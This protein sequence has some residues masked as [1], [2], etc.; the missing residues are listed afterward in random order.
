M[1]VMAGAQA[2]V[3]PVRRRGNGDTVRSSLGRQPAGLPGDPLLTNQR[4][5]LRSAGKG[6]IQK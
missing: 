5:Q 1:E 6:R 2:C 4:A 3:D